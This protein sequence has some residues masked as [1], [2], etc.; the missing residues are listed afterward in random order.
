MRQCVTHSISF[1]SLQVVVDPRAEQQFYI[2]CHFLLIYL[3]CGLVLLLSTP[4]DLKDRYNIKKI[5]WAS[6][7]VAS[8]TT[9]HIWYIERRP[10]MFTQI[11]RNSKKHCFTYFSVPTYQM[12]AAI[13]S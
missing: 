3:S 4:L 13:E 1:R 9:A 2:C 11:Q 8:K 6:T 10:Q 5:I 12:W 7:L